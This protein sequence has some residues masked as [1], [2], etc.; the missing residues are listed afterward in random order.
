MPVRIVVRRFDRRGVLEKRRVPLARLAAL[1]SV[2]VVEALA[3]RPAIEW[4]RG[5]QFVVRRVV[6]LSKGRRAVVIA[7]EG[8]GDAGGLPRPGTVVAG[9]PGRHFRDD[10]RVDGVV[11]ATREQR[12][13]GRRTQRGGGKAVV[14]QTSIGQ[15]LQRR[16]VRWSAKRARLT[17]PDVVE[18][19]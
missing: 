18:H 4:T 11:I 17:E 8:F 5:A 9:K 3:R 10:A 7:S 19:D 15:P 6:P 2:P 12:G 13:P 16:R 1:E 14:T